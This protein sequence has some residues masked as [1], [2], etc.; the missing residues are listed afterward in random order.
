MAHVALT[1][2]VIRSLSM[3]QS[4]PS[5][6]DKSSSYG[7]TQPV[8]LRLSA[9][10][11]MRSP[12]TQST[13]MGIISEWCEFLGAKAGSKEAAKKVIAATDLH[14][15][16]YKNWLE[17]KPGERPRAQRKGSLSREVRIVSGRSA[18]KVGLEHT[19]SN[20]TIAKKFA[21]LRRI[22][23]MLIG[24]GVGVKEN[25]FDSDRVPAPPKAAGRKRPTEMVD[26][27]MVQRIVNA[28]DG[29][30]AKGVQDR[31]ILAVFFGG[32][33]RRAEVLGLRCGDIRRSAKG[34][35][36]L[37]LRST[38]AKKDAEQALPPW[39]SKLLLAHLE[40]RRKQGAREADYLFVSFRGRAGS[41]ATESPLS[42]AGLY[43]MFK[44]YCSK[45]DAG[46]F[47]S[48]HS[49]RATAI[50]KLLSDGIPHRQ[51]QEFSRHSS[52]QM[53][54]L[55]DKRR[56]GVDENPAKLLDYE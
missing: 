29:K 56:M 17:K 54:E 47:L 21:A 23:R 26:F 33:L 30:S 51:V 15:I 27:A 38:K 11:S 13:Y 46:Q 44:F 32:G 18:K 14:A 52:I 19:L 34:T 20:A 6:I 55:Y 35:I 1:R 22:Y 36:F 50:T 25:P 39:A 7:Q 10:L 42:P 37:Y 40:L 3:N 9:F 49:A 31:A 8:W 16:A 24:A 53:V 28:P 4:L 45:A 41:K 5:V 12:N 2:R 43:K 48:P